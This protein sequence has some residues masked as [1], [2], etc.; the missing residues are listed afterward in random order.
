[1][2]N[3]ITL[4]KKYIDLLDE[5]YK[6]AAVTSLLDGDNALVQRGANANEIIIPKISMQAQQAY[7]RLRRRLYQMVR[8]QLQR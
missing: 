8:L 7:Q 1:M 3:N 6:Q 4:F 2:A 5:V